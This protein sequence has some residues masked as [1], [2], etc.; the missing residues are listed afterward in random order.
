MEHVP[1]DHFIVGPLN[2]EL[3]GIFGACF[4]FA[5]NIII[6]ADGFSPNEA[7]LKIGMNDACC[8]WRG[9]PA[10]HRPCAG[11]FRANR[12]KRQQVEQIIAGSNQ[13]CETGLGKAKLGQK[14]TLVISIE[15]A[16]FSLNRGR[17]DNMP[18]FLRG[19]HFGDFLAV[20]IAGG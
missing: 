8:L 13:T 11:L 7:A 15:L 10:G 9:C 19:R 20:I 4:A 6:K 16:D 3:A 1:V 2:A 5:D 18:G 12:E 17:N 14:L